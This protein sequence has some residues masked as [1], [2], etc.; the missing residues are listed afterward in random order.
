MEDFGSE[1]PSGWPK[2]LVWLILILGGAYLLNPT[3]GMDLIP[4]N[5]PIAGNLDEVAIFILWLGALHNLGVDLPEFI[6]GSPTRRLPPP[7][8]HDDELD[9]VVG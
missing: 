8:S 7:D 1:K 9:D 3:F 2:W 4:D 5:I 6:S